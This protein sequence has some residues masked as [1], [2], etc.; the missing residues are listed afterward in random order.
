MEPPVAEELSPPFI[1][2]D[3]PSFAAVPTW[4]TIS[5]ETTCESPD[6]IDISPESLCADP[7]ASEIPPLL[8]A[9][10]EFAV[11]ILTV[12]D[13]VARPVPLVTA[14]LPPVNV[15]LFPAFIRTDPP[16]PAPA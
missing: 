9:T 11:A 13:E 15:S 4:N 5:P 1:K 16:N 10:P 7:L 2:S 8:P 12:P 6:C 3:P 14:M